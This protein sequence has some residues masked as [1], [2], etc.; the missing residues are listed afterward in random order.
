MR[1]AIAMHSAPTVPMSPRNGM[2]VTLRASSATSTV[3]PA[4]TTALPEVP[5]A[6]AIDSCSSSPAL[7]WR[8]CRLTMKSE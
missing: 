5:F 1:T 3:V 6:S 2:P 7:S 8:R 4:N